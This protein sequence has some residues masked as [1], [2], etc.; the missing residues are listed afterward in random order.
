M[1]DSRLDSVE[2]GS[3]PFPRGGLENVLILLI[4]TR[5]FESAVKAFQAAVEIDP[6]FEMPWYG[7][8]RAHL[9]LKQFVAATSALS[10]CRDLYV[11]Q[12]GRQFTSQQEAQSGS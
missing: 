7:L 9:A 5:E 2:K 10:R 6:V 3:F 12:G 11:Q 1:I 4:P 8:G